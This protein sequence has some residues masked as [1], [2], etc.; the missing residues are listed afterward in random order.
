M[1]SKA[2]TEVHQNVVISCS[3]PRTTRNNNMKID[4]GV[5]GDSGPSTSSLSSA[6]ETKKCA[7]IEFTLDG[8][9]YVS[10]CPISWIVGKNCTWPSKKGIER[11]AI[12]N[13]MK[14]END[15]VLLENV[16]ILG[17]YDTYIEALEKE[18]RKSVTDGTSSDDNDV[19]LSK[20]KIRK[21]SKYRDDSP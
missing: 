14:P 3:T 2:K 17:K 21:N 1:S 4:K 9:L 13:N 5:M 10:T 8:T 12:I 6:V 11:K 20:R 15:W 19:L 18:K 16:N 7:L